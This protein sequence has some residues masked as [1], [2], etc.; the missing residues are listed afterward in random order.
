MKQLT[1]ENAREFALEKFKELPELNFNG[2]L[3]I[4]KK[5]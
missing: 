4:L 5:L 3:F 2:I 1:E